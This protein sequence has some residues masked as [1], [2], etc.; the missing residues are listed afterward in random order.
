MMPMVLI[1]LI[2]YFVL[3]L[4][5]R[6]KQKRLEAMVSALKPGDRIIVNPG[7]LGTVVSL[8]GDDTVQV[9][10]DEKTK[11]R[12]LRSAVSGLQDAPSE[13]EKK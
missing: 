11:I 3:I 6:N 10:V 1:F 4:P 2:F 9:R 13:T 7:I 8:E 5:A 12:V